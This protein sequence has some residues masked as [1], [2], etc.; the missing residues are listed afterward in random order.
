LNANDNSRNEEEPSSSPQPQD[1]AEAPT[2][3]GGARSHSG[4]ARAVRRASAG[5]DGFFDVRA[6]AADSVDP[7]GA[8]QGLV[9][10]SGG[11]DRGRD[12]LAE[13][14]HHRRG[15]IRLSGGALPSASWRIG[16]QHPVER[17]QVVAVVLGDDLAV[18]TSGAYARGAH[19]FDPHTRRAPKAYCR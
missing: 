15:D 4:G 2:K 19:V 8:R 17:Q 6:R 13:L 16:I 14:R 10:R 5:D 1:A 7:S 3:A 11:R 9:G 18:A 12:R